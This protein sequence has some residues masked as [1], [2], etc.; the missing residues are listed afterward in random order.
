MRSSLPATLAHIL[1]HEG[2]WADDQK[3]PGGCNMRGITL[4]TWRDHGHPRATCATLRHITEAD[5]EGIYRATYWAQ[6]QG[7]RLPVGLDLLVCDHGVN[8]GPARAVRLLQGLVGAKTDGDLG[9]RT[10]F[11]LE[12]MMDRDGVAVVVRYA[13]ARRAYYRSLPKT[14]FRRFGKGWLA[15]VDAAEMAAMNL[16]ESA[17]WA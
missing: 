6:V 17:P 10:L 15:R 3:D 16:V 8:A 14:Q 2:G 4:A 5:A 12:Y 13:E 7:D 11:A 1:A 9:P